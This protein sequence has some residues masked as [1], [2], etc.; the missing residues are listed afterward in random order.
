MSARCAS[1]FWRIG[2]LVLLAL[3][4]NPSPLL[5]ADVK[6]GVNDSG[7]KDKDQRKYPIPQALE[8][9]ASFVAS[10]IRGH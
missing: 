4:L 7:K 2:W 6:N 3:F 1:R 9:S 5:H 10:R 8:R